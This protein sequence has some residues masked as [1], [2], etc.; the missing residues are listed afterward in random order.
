MM[1]EAEKLLLSSGT[2]INMQS[3][4]IEDNEDRT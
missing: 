3:G 2:R 1:I 4:V